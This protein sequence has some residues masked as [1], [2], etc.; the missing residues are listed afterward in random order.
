MFDLWRDESGVTTV[1]YALLLALVALVALVSWQ[2][3]GGAVDNT[4]SSSATA[5][6]SIPAPSNASP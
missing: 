1:E 2:N 4:A 3:L 5:M 6:G